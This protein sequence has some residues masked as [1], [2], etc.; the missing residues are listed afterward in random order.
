MKIVFA[1]DFYFPLIGGIEV[2]THRLSQRLS[3]A[4]NQVYIITPSKS[5][6][7]EM[8]KEGLVTIFGISSIQ[9]PFYESYRYSPS[10][11]LKNKISKI[12]AEIKPDVVHIQTNMGI[13]RLGSICARKFGIPT[14]ATGHFMTEDLVCTLKLPH[15]LWGFVN[16][17]SYYLSYFIWKNVDIF[18]TP[19]DTAAS[20]FAKRHNFKKKTLIVSNGV[21]TKKFRLHRTNQKRTPTIAVIGR[22]DSSKRVDVIIKALPKILKKI[23]VNLIIVGAGLEMQNLKNMTRRLGIEKYVTFKGFLPE[24]KV[25]KIYQRVDLLATASVIETQGLAVLEALSSG[26]PIVA[27]NAGAIPE[28]IKNGKNGYLFEPGDSESLANQ[29]IKILSNR[30]LYED[31][32][33]EAIKIAKE[34]DIEEVIVKMENVYQKAMSLNSLRAFR[35]K[36]TP[37]YLS[38]GFVLK[39]A[40]AGLVLSLL[41]RNVLVSP[42]KV[43]A[44]ELVIKN[45]IMNSKIV[46]KMEGL[47]L[48]LKATTFRKAALNSL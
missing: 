33:R 3:E 11:L 38:K 17:A 14:V 23:R 42:S 6:K 9:I 40:V 4:G 29:V 47:D 32:S 26:L 46:K 8:Y 10:L 36:T 7:D 2:S 48:K 18:T 20:Y 1:T 35:T 34:H 43:S 27:T 25:V 41:F 19:T 15:F 16:R 37:F 24:D 44:R 13:G 28:L 5:F 39:F 31:M 22:L 30:S 45:K 21:D 12:F